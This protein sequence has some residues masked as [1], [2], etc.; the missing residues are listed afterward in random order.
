MLSFYD[1]AKP[2]WRYH[3]I[4]TTICTGYCLDFYDFYIVGFLLASLGPRWQI[5]FTD[6]LGP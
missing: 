3:G 5:R 2:R 1:R 4:F 6:K